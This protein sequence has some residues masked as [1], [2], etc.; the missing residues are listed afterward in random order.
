MTAGDIYS[1]YNVSAGTGGT[2]IIPAGST[3]VLITAISTD[4]SSNSYFTLEGN[5]IYS[6]DSSSST[7]NFAQWVESKNIKLFVNNSHY[8]GFKSAAGTIFGGY[9]GIEI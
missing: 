3:K 2:N 4:D 7:N 9:S 6:G 8:F 5:I 1:D